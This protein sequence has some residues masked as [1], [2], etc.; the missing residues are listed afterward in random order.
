MP[1]NVAIIGA[2]GKMGFRAAEKI[3]AQPG[4]S[5]AMCE[6]NEERAAA[7]AAKGFAV[8]QL[9]A[10]LAEADFVFLAVPDALIGRISHQCA[11]LMKTGAMM[12][13]LDAAAAYAGEMPT[14]SGVQMMITH[15]CHP[16]FFTEQATPEARADYFGGTAL[17]DIIVCLVEGEEAAFQRGVEICRAVFS[18]VKDAHRVTVEQ[19]AFLEPAMSELLVGA[20][21]QW[22]KDAL[23]ATVAA[24]VPRTAAEAFMAGHAQIAIAICFGAEKSPFSDA[25]KLAVEWGTRAYLRPEWRNVFQPEVLKS[26]IAEMIHPEREPSV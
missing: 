2:G 11:P 23:E 12:I 8:T 22:M 1:S 13:A 25:A 15:P 19:F 7:L 10:A 3:G 14:G 9:D 16:P 20:A 6:A 26:A 21:A 24:G 17:Q 5:V 4:Y 18:P